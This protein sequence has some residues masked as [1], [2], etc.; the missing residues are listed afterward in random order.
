MPSRTDDYTTS[1]WVTSLFPPDFGLRIKSSP[2]TFWSTLVQFR[3]IQ[4]KGISPRDKSGTV[5]HARQ[6]LNA[7]LSAMHL[8]MCS[9]RTRYNALSP[10]SALPAEV[11]ARIFQFCTAMWLPAEEL[12]DPLGW[13]KV[14][15]VC[16]LWR[17]V[18]LQFP[19]L[20]SDICFTLGP[21]CAKAML[22]RSKLAPISIHLDMTTV[23]ER[24]FSY[25]CEHFPHTRQLLLAGPSNILKSIIDAFPRPPAIL[26]S[27]DINAE[28]SFPSDSFELPEAIAGIHPPSLRRLSLRA[29]WVPWS[30]PIL[31]SL[32]YLQIQL[33]KPRNS[34][35]GPYSGS[36]WDTLIGAL[37]N[38]PTLEHLILKDC[39]PSASFQDVGSDALQLP[40][41]KALLLKG[42]SA[43]CFSIARQ[44]QIAPSCRV[45]L[46]C[47]DDANIAEI[48]PFLTAHVSG[49]ADLPPWGVLSLIHREQF[50]LELWR[51]PDTLIFE[52]DRFNFKPKTYA[53]V[54][55]AFHSQ[56]QSLR[57][58]EALCQAMPLQ[59]IRMLCIGVDVDTSYSDWSDLLGQCKNVERAS[60]YGDHGTSFCTALGMAVD[61]TSASKLENCK[62]EDLFL[63]NLKTL[64]L[65]WVDF[66][67]WRHDDGRD[68]DH[69]RLTRWLT[70]R[71]RVQAVPKLA[72]E[73]KACSI[74]QSWV[75]KLK[76]EAVVTWDGDEGECED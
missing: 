29:F 45:Q 14:T 60:I 46:R 4:T 6:T 3:L 61:Y 67:H 11:L 5:V 10:I 31:R 68:V 35:A 73:L 2:Q 51:L 7:E 27:M 21:Q 42:P 25:L 8:A 24:N 57:P 37:R 53:D 76:K 23:S 15:H 12:K 62:Q 32:T 48:L 9:L 63:G 13:I 34:P 22:A 71:R 33:L 44:L 43:A 16:R 36:S 26:E 69:L 40:R 38:M 50:C 19:N 54:V 72:I 59:T 49:G 30:A 55:I 70:N 52:R 18:A 47:N 56:E 17:H 74:K 20:W 28:T 58:F 1:E 75:R 41:L 66:R 39:F 65:S 64:Q